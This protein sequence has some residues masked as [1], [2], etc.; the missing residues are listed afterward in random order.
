MKNN[1]LQ[2]AQ[3][4]P[5]FTALLL[6]NLVLALI[7]LWLFATALEAAVAERFGVAVPAAIASACCFAINAWIYL[8]VRKIGEE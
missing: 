6:F 4:A 8:G 1:K 2:H 5:I 3:K 7:Q